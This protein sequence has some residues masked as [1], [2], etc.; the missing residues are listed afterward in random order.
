MG[1]NTSKFPFTVARLRKLEAPAKG[2]VYHYDTR[3]SGLCVCVTHKGTKTYYLYKKVNGRPQRIRLGVFPG[4]PLDTARM[5]AEKMLGDVAM[6]ADPAEERRARREVMTFA[7]LFAWYMDHHSRPHKKTWRVDQQQYDRYL[8]KRWAGRKINT[9]RKRDAQALHTKIGADHG[10]YAANRLRALVH[11]VFNQ[12]IDKGLC[13]GPNPTQGVKKFTEKKRDRFLDGE[14]LKRFFLALDEEPSDKVRDYLKVALFTGARRTN[15]LEMQWEEIDFATHLWRIPDTKTGEP[16]VVPLTQQA[17][18]VLTQRREYADGSPWVFPG[19]G[20]TGH[21]TDPTRIWKRVLRR[22][23]LENLRLHDLRRTLGSWQ[24]MTGASLHV[25]G[26]SL[27]HKQTSTTEI[28]AR[29]QTD[30]IRESVDKATAAMLEAAN[31]KGAD[32]GDE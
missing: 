12:A 5:V 22:A 10:H 25:I 17:L 29:L 4:M 19:V 24:A 9:I 7:E 28:Y 2:R 21:L 32:H 3:T 14:E 15:V 27:G 26:K 1:S 13:E 20:K 18:D 16:L 11:T 8:K 6:G 23:G 31:G 30:P